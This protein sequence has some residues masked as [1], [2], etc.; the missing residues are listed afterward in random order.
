MI[1]SCMMVTLMMMIMIILIHSLIFFF[2]NKLYQFF[3]GGF[4]QF[5]LNSLHFFSILCYSHYLLKEIN[6][7]KTQ[8]FSKYYFL[9]K[10]YFLYLLLVCHFKKYEI[11]VAAAV[12]SCISFL[13]HH[14]NHHHTWRILYFKFDNVFVTFIQLFWIYIQTCECGCVYCAVVAAYSV[15]PLQYHPS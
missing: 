15:F 9:K 14:R 4:S 11:N 3:K 6:Q 5:I 12:V 13:Y 8:F 2:V 1:S 7:K 10:E